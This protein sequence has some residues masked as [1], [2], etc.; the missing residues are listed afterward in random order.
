[1]TK[2]I[3]AHAAGIIVGLLFVGG[4][5]WFLLG[6]DGTAETFKLLNPFGSSA[7][8][9]S[10]TASGLPEPPAGSSRYTHPARGFSF[11]YP[12]GFAVSSFEEGGGEMVL[13]E[14]GGTGNGFQIFIA[15]FDELGPITVERI[16]QDLPDIP[17][18]EPQQT[19]IS[20]IPALAF[21]GSDPSA[22]KTR[23]VWFAENGQLYQVSAF[24]EFDEELSS[25][26]ATFRFP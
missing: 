12:E 3:S 7:S 24:L 11:Q 14:G 22:G 26:L 6:R 4:L 8:D 20:G 15:P 17:I 5:S 10:A 1:M 21:V 13:A 2:R 19:E 16:R 9:T 23:E 25:I 18:E